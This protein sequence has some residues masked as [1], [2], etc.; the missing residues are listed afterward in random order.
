M[1][2]EDKELAKI[3]KEGAAKLDID[4]SEEALKS[5]FTYL[6]ELKA[7]NKKI[8]LTSIDTDREIII[9]HFLDSLIPNRFLGGAKTLLDIGA[10]G[11]FPGIP[12]KIINPALS[13]TLLDSVEKKVHFMRHIIRT[14]G[15]SNT[16]AVAA[17]IEDPNF[18][19]KNASRFDCVISRA[20]A[21]LDQFITLALPY[22]VPSGMILAV[23]GPSVYDELKKVQNPGLS[24]PEIHEITVPFSDRTTTIIIYRKII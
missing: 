5:F 16:F 18:I 20:F 7:W 3:L 11:G 10:G 2:M 21:E 9:K 8:N 14:L 19:E 13:V 4:L 12:L 6:K 24:Q 1:R 15:L 17:R 23:K 22:V